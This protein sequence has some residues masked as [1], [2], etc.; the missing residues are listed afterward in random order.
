MYL[1]KNQ[2]KRFK[3]GLTQIIID[4][5]KSATIIIPSGAINVAGTATNQ[6]NVTPITINDA[7]K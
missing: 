4:A 2:K 7:I 1:N 6:T 5:I 3:Q